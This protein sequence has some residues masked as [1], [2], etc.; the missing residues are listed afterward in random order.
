M[1]NLAWY[2]EDNLFYRKEKDN[3]RTNI[4]ELLTMTSDMYSKLRKFVK[5]L[6]TSRCTA[7]ITWQNEQLSWTETY[8]NMCLNILQFLTTL[9]LSNTLN[10]F[11]PCYP[12]WYMY[13]YVECYSIYNAQFIADWHSNFMTYMYVFL[14]TFFMFPHVSL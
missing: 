6:S 5:G 10:D 12:I 1:T 14:H 8:I 2:V 11:P 9:D 3:G 7:D 13:M 4:Q